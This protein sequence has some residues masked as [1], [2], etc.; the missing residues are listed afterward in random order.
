VPENPAHGTVGLKT[1]SLETCSLENPRYGKSGPLVIKD[2][3]SNKLNTSN[4][5]GGGDQCAVGEIGGEIAN[6]S[7]PHSAPVNQVVAQKAVSV[8]PPQPTRPAVID[9][10]FQPNQET[11]Q[12]LYQHRIPD[13]FINDQIPEFISYWRELGVK[14]PTW[15]NTFLKNVKKNW[16]RAQANGNHHGSNQ[17]E[18]RNTSRSR[19]AAGRVSENAERERREWATASQALG[20]QPVGEDGAAVWPQVDDGVWGRDRPDRHVGE[21]IDGDYTRADS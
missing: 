10:N 3:P 1:R 13:Q 20:G 8:T 12:W 16:E 7:P 17:H 4:D 14:R 11:R 9:L 19:S 18:K 15:Q 21:D 2:L 5:G 6:S